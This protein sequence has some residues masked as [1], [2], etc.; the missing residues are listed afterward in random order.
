ME[1]IND[2]PLNNYVTIYQKSS[3]KD[4]YGDTTG[5]TATIT[6]CAIFEGQRKTLNRTG[7]EVL[8]TARVAVKSKPSIDSLVYLSETFDLSP[9][10]DSQEI[11]AI[12]TIRDEWGEIV[13]YW[14]WL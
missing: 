9:P 13:G 5:Y 1:Y 6:N 10:A 14:I 11:I 2:N 8:S 4:E 7:Q 12:N 3:I